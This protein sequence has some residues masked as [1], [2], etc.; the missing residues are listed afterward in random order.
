MQSYEMNN[1]SRSFP[2]EGKYTFLDV[3][4]PNIYTDT[5]C[6]ISLIVVED[7]VEVLRHTELINPKT[8]FS[9]QNIS[10]H[11]IRP[12]DVKNARTFKEFYSEF[13]P[14]L[15]DD[16]ILC[17][18]NINSDIS[19]INRDLSRSRQS[20]QARRC[21]DTS[22]VMK[23]IYY[24]GNPEKG[25]LRLKNAAKTLNIAIHS[26]D[27]A[28]DVNACYEIV[29]TLAKDHDFSLEQFVRNIPESKIYSPYIMRKNM[30]ERKARKLAAKKKSS[31]NGNK[32]N[33]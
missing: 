29:R 5:V 19:I 25:G 20:L 33:E 7:G 10:V 16:Y 9:G 11:K 18:H 14:Y 2:F 26:H 27:P 23:Q 13:K 6:A 17:G 24:Q 4:N 15:S 12:K 32:E 28:S 30:Q 3:E 22:D 31:D 1:E 21:I 8:F